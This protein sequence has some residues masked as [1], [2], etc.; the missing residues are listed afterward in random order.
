MKLLFTALYLLLTLAGI[1]QLPAGFVKENY[2]KKE[3]YITTKDGVKLFTVIY[4]PKDQKEKYPIKGK[5]GEYYEWRMDM[6]TIEHFEE[7]DYM[8][9]LSYIGVLPE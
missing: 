9:A 2:Q 5:E 4:T 7:K 6:T 8:E 1:S 3:T